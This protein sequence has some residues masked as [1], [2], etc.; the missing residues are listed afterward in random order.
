MNAAPESRSAT[1]RAHRNA[2]LTAE[3]RL[4]LCLRVDAGCPIA[5]VAA[6]AGIYRRCLTKWYTRWRARR[7]RT[8]RPPL[9]PCRCF[10][11]F[12][13][14][15][16]LSRTHCATGRWHVP[17]TVNLREVERLPRHGNPPL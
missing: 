7:K 9:P 14:G 10:V 17:L 11:Y 15:N 1:S 13:I 6:E 3:G 8:A 5:H 16:G 4:R 12:F 2:P